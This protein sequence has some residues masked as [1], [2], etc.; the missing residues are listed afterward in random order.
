MSLIYLA[1]SLLSARVEWEFVF[2]SNAKL[3]AESL[4]GKYYVSTPVFDDDNDGLTDFAYYRG[5]RQFIKL[6]L[7]TPVHCAGGTVNSLPVPEAGTPHIAPAPD[8]GTPR[9]DCHPGI[10]QGTRSG[11]RRYCNPVGRETLTRGKMTQSNGY[12]GGQV[13]NVITC[14]RP[15]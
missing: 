12:P 8:S 3:S 15:R 10:R 11:E 5:R 13:L 7:R 2:P 6:S 14:L 4:M 9:L 1:H